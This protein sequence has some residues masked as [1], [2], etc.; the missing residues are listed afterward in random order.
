METQYVYLLQT[1][2]FFNSKQPVYKIGRT[3]KHNLT[4]FSQ[5]TLGSVLLFQSSCRD[6]YKLEREII[7]LFKQKYI[8]KH[9]IGRESFEGDV[10]EM[11]RDLCDIIKYERETRVLIV[12]NIESTQ[13]VVVEEIRHC[14]END[15]NEVMKVDNE[16]DIIN[17]FVKE[18]V[19]CIVEEN[20]PDVVVEE[21]CVQDVNE[22]EC[23]QYVVENEIIQAANEDIDIIIEDVENDNII[24]E[25]VEED[26][27]IC[28][29]VRSE[30]T[31]NNVK[32]RFICKICHFDTDTNGQ[33]KQHSHSQKHL[34][35][36][37]N[38]GDVISPYKCSKCERGYQTRSG[39][40][41]HKL[42]CKAPEVAS[43]E[44]VVPITLELGN[45]DLQT[46]IE[47]LERVIGKLTS[48]V[49]NNLTI[50]S[51]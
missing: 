28:Q 36:L 29:E 21:E 46:K 15:G 17:D 22:E 26:V 44:V 4:R 5:Y 43:P 47:N 51:K 49:E 30:F 27:V 13:E 9:L 35:N 39:L 8:H 2:E 23:V 11:V 34:K 10:D 6:C 14:E 48:L 33:L 50:A 20:I 24:C 40:Q 38:K 16:N 45:I 1:R 18:C 42:V 19:Q 25:D 37:E 12:N 41:K 3:K 32:G 7:T 31:V